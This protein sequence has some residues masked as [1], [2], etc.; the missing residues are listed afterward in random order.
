MA[1]SDYLD[2]SALYWSNDEKYFPEVVPQAEAIREGDI[3]ISKIEPSFLFCS[4]HGI[5]VVFYNGNI[6]HYSYGMN[7]LWKST[8]LKKKENGILYAACLSGDSLIICHE[9]CFASI[10][11]GT[12]KVNWMRTV[13][14]I[15]EKSPAAASGVEPAAA[16]RVQLFTSHG[17]VELDCVSGAR[18][19]ALAVSGWT[20]EAF[21][22]DKMLV[23]LRTDVARMYQRAVF[24]RR[25]FEL[26]VFS[27]DPAEMANIARVSWLGGKFYCIARKSELR[28]YD[29]LNNT[30]GEPLAVRGTGWYRNSSNWMYDG[31]SLFYL[32]AT[33]ITQFDCRSGEKVAEYGP[34]NLPKDDVITGNTCVGDHE[35]WAFTYGCRWVR[36]PKTLRGD[37]RVLET[38]LTGS[39]D[40]FAAVWGDALISLSFQIDQVVLSL[41]KRDS[42]GVVAL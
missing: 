12:G 30:M 31:K 34:I 8:G 27:T 10:A 32:T 18:L 33:T 39:N 20:A 25:T 1:K 22:G 15:T 7:L 3:A 19:R 37:H 28:I 2:Q 14:D 16:G 4:K 9:F 23:W 35:I 29:H 17:P 6:H 38:G 11:V 26:D 24:D 5:T 41:R 40:A 42:A 21:F 13:A 36:I